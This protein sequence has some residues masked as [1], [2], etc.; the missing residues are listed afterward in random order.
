M[1]TEVSSAEGRSHARIVSRRRFLI[2]AGSTSSL[3]LLAACQGGAPQPPPASTQEPV[4]ARTREPINVAQPTPVV[5]QAAPAAGKP[6]PQG[7]FTEAWNTTISPAWLDP[8]ENPPQITPY[9]FQLA[10]H[11]ALVKHVPGKPLAPSLAESA[12]MAPDYKSATFKLRPGIKFHDGSPVTPEDVKFT[13]KEP[14]L[15]FMLV[16]GSPPAGPAG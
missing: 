10:L 11:D 3:V 9:N 13:F 4:V 6:Q 12:E 7:K 8:Q 14:F 5:Q 16:Y 2:F 15:D 1:P